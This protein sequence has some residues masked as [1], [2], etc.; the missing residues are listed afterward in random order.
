MTTFKKKVFTPKSFVVRVGLA[1]IYLPVL[2]KAL[3]RPQTSAALREKVMLA[4]TAVND[5]RYCAW[6]HTRLALMNGIALDEVNDLLA[7]SQVSAGSD[8]DGAAILFA[9]HFAD[10]DGKV[11][12]DALAA[13][14]KYYNTAQIREIKA[15]IHTIF[16]NNLAG[17]SF[18]ALLARFSIKGF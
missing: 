1:T 9:Q 7:L 10:S 13:L 6:A 12:A 18:D 4:V 16:M 5:C 8:A 2:V 3:V 15:Y 14:S 11:D 17:N